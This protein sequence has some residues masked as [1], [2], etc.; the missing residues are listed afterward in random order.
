MNT[1]SEDLLNRILD[2]PVGQVVTVLG[3]ILN[4]NIHLEVIEQNAITPHQF[5]RKIAIIA[6]ELPVIKAYVEFD[7]TVLPESIVSDLLKKKRGV[8][9]ILNI[10]NI[11]ATRNVISFNR[12]PDDALVLRKYEI[13]Y[14]GIV[15]F[16]ILEEIRLD[17]L[18]SNNNS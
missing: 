3:E 13:L 7:P 10:N 5:V 6:N 11:K 1:I 4:C 14:D 15:W 9:T 8:G 2:A 12:N 17:N 16:T 18:G